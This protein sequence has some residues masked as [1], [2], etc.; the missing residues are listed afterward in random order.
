MTSCMLLDAVHSQRTLIT[1]LSLSVSL[2]N[3]PTS[4]LFEKYVQLTE[5]LKLQMYVIG[6]DNITMNL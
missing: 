1:V 4:L 3:N 6:N 2:Y 5:I